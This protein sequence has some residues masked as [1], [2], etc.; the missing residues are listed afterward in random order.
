MDE[1]GENILDLLNAYSNESNRFDGTVSDI[2]DCKCQLFEERCEQS[3][4]HEY[5]RRIAFSTMLC[6]IARQLYFDFLKS[7]NLELNVLV[8]EM[9]TRFELLERGQAHLREWDRITLH[10]MSVENPQ[11]S[12]KE[13]LEKLLGR[14][15]DLQ[16]GLPE[17]YLHNTIHRDKLMNAVCNVVECAVAHQKPSEAVQGMILDLY[18]CLAN[19]SKITTISDSSLANN[20]IPLLD[21]NANMID[22]YSIPNNNSN[23]KRNAQ[24][25][26]C[27]K[28][29]C[30]STKHSTKE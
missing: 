19:A 3:E 21:I 11:L 8:S 12:S 14:I 15:S 2:F 9:K 1:N 30:W 13:C 5:Q 29:G 23:H 10:K 4:L 6:G 26:V 18:A 20:T 27:N 24:C 17:I 7:N 22:R 16:T 28:K 25:I